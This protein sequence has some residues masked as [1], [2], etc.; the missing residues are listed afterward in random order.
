[1]CGTCQQPCAAPIEGLAGQHRWAAIGS[2]GHVL[3]RSDRPR[4]L[5]RW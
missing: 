5:W 3:H 1:M 4:D 2:S